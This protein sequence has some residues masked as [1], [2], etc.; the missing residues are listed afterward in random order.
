MCTVVAFTFLAS[1]IN[2]P[3]VQ[4]RGAMD[5]STTHP[6]FVEAPKDLNRLALYNANGE[7]VA[8][9]EKKGEI[10]GACKMETGV[11]LDDLMNA[12][13]HAYIEIQK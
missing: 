5:P 13:V 2:A 1:M 7:L 11:S 8:R 4:N 12:W 9:C 6:V 3:A 10:F